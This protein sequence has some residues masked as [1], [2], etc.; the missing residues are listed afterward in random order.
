MRLAGTA[1][2][3]A[4]ET[5][6]AASGPSLLSF[7]RRYGAPASLVAGYVASQVVMWTAHNKSLSRLPLLQATVLNLAAN[8]LCSGALGL[9]LFEESQVLTARWLLGCGLVLAGAW[10]IGSSFERDPARQ[11]G[12]RR[13]S[14]EEEEEEEEETKKAA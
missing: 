4:S 13:R 9:A 14:R 3:R 2:R 6:A 5:E 1:G 11:A 12:G 10:L 7:L 8:T